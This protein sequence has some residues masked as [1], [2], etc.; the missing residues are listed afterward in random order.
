MGFGWYFLTMYCVLCTVYYV[1]C[2]MYCVRG[3]ETV[4]NSAIRGI[5]AEGKSERPV[6]EYIHTWHGALPNEVSLHM[7]ILG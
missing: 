7:Y 3:N 2:T 1:L 5:G 6:Y 4:K